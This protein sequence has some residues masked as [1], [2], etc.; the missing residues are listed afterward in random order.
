MLVLPSAVRRWCRSQFSRFTGRVFCEPAHAVNCL[1]RPLAKVCADKLLGLSRTPPTEYRCSSTRDTVARCG[2]KVQGGVSVPDRQSVIQR[3]ANR[4]G[5]ACFPLLA[6]VTGR[7]LFCVASL[8]SVTVAP[9]PSAAFARGLSS[10]TSCR[11]AR[12]ESRLP[13]AVVPPLLPC[14]TSLECPRCVMLDCFRAFH[15]R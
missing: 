13:V 6:A 12:G 7:W 3:L 15:D 11:T 9:Q 4:A 14:R 10:A 1:L 5:S 8:E 2:A